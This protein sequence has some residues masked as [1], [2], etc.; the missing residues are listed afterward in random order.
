MRT[1]MYRHNRDENGI[2]HATIATIRE[3]EVVYFGIARCCP[4]DTFTKA[5]GR[6]IAM[7]RA[8]KEKA[9]FPADDYAAMIGYSDNGLRGMCHVS[10]IKNVLDYFRSL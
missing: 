4:R 8:L 10:C 7:N 1:E 2:P 5:K 9:E 6:M 3:G